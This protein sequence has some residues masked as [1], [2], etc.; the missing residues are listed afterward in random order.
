M[1][2]H[3]ERREVILCGAEMTDT[4][5]GS[6]ENHT[7]GTNSALTRPATLVTRQ[8]RAGHR[9]RSAPT[10]MCS[11]GNNVTTRRVLKIFG[12]V[13]GTPQVQELFPLLQYQNMQICYSFQLNL[14]LNT[15]T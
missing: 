9:V 15:L 4:L 10:K 7:P 11:G 2:Q 6:A 13:G 3:V 12:M 5:N 8:N 1:E 14:G